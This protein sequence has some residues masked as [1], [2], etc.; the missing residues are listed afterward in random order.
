MSGRIFMTWPEVWARCPY[1][2]WLALGALDDADRRYGGH[3]VL[4]CARYESIE[5]DVLAEAVAVLDRGQTVLL[6]ADRQDMFDRARREILA[7]AAATA[8]VA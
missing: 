3:V 8:G 5:P 1:R 6:L 2:A 7:M 4:R